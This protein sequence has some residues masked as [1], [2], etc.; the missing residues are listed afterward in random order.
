MINCNPETVSTD[1]DTSDRLYFE[2]LTL[3]DVLAVCEVEQPAGVIVQFG[4]QTPLKLAAGLEEAGV[5]ILGTSIDAIDL[6]EDRSRFGALLDR[7][8]LQGAAVRDRALAR[9]G[10]RAGARASASRCSSARATCSAAARWRSSTA[11]TACATT[12]SRVG[13][14][15]PERHDLPRPL[16]RGLD[17]GR[18]RRAVRR[19]PT[20]G[21]PG[22]C[23]TSRRPGSTRATRPACCRRTRSARRC[24]PRSAS[25]PRGSRGR[26]ASSGCSNVQF[27]IHGD[28]GL[29]VIEANPRASRTVPF[30]SK[31]IGLPLAKLACRVL[32]GERIADLDLP[33][34]TTNGHV[35]V[36][37]VVLPF[38]RFAGA[39]SLLGPE[40]RS[41]GEVMGIARD[42]P[43]AFAKAQAAA[44]AKLPDG[45]TVFITVADGDKPAATGHRHDPARPRLRD[46]RHPRHRAGDPQDGHPG[47]GD[48]QDRRGLAARGRLDRAR[49]GR[50]RDQHPGRHRRPHRRLRDPRGRDRPRDPVHHDDDRRDGRRPGDRGRPARGEPEV[51][52]LQEIHAA[53][54]PSPDPVAPSTADASL[55]PFGRRARG[56]DRARAPRRLRGAPLL[57][58]RTARARSPASSTCWPPPSGGAGETASG[59]SCP[60]AF[61]VL[62]APPPTRRDRAAVPDRG[63]RPGHQA[64]VRAR[65]RRRAAAGRT[66]RR[67]ASRRRARAAAP[68]LVGGGV[69]IAPLAIWQ[70]ELG[71]E[72][73]GAARLP[74]RSARRRAPRCCRARAVATDDGSVGHHGLVTEL[75]A[76]ELDAAATSV[77]VY[78]CGPPAML[79]A[80]R[81][82]LRRARR[83]GPARARVRDGVRVR[84]LLRLRGADPRR[85]RPAVRRRARCS[86]RAMLRDRAS[87]PGAGH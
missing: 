52:S 1:Y 39:D 50:P 84:R 77:E 20:C 6:A 13:D 79:E 14:A 42:F 49:R 40:M 15:G 35:C 53:R 65:A 48:Q 69:G 4:G 44:G 30:V 59:R 58:T 3:E 75:L 32:L 16:P 66:A 74:R 60:R 27:A 17:R 70:D 78:A 2:P 47:R 25:R 19:R 36:K 45:G 23:S 5:P 83:P 38:D 63:R 82:D 22:S 18:R 64:A 68:L 33:A 67:R 71:A 28:A 7:A 72:A 41:T 21:S 9:G 43:T 34:D 11:S 85:L 80:V 24:S 56:G 12:S 10:A 81:G 76:D 86:T 57:A 51:L 62:R 31:A 26:S 29:H 87:W 73:A 54:A 55:A 46:R 8:R 37:E 61:S